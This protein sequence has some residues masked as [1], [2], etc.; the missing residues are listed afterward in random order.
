MSPTSRNF[1][2]ENEKD[3]I[4]N[5]ILEAEN[6]TSGE[7][8]LHI[9]N[10]CEEEVLDRAAFVF[11]KLKMDKTA[12]RNGVLFY[13]AIDSKKFAIIG[14]KGINAVVPEDFWNKIKDELRKDFSEGKFSEGL[15]KGIK[16]AGESLKKHFP[17]QSDDINELSDDISFG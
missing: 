11:N 12:A 3:K 13:L 9:E 2:S 4:L 16:A 7:I 14:D 6:N 17:H 15:V 8:R 1:F 5:A 10:E